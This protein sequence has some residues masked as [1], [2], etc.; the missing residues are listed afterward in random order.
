MQAQL[1][2]YA[3]AH[4]EKVHATPQT[5]QV[6]E[7]LS[8]AL[9]HVICKATDLTHQT[10]LKN[11]VKPKEYYSKNRQSTKEDKIF[12]IITTNR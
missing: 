4:W 10:K 5:Q 1:T 3:P 7:A 11:S 8:R 9:R 2:L 6:E 12:M